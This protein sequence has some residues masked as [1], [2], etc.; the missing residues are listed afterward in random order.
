MRFCITIDE[1][2]PCH[3]CCLWP[4]LVGFGQSVLA[5]GQEAEGSCDLVFGQMLWDLLLLVLV[6]G[7]EPG[8]VTEPE[9][10]FQSCQR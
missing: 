4:G 3:V 1:A 7:R 8:R 6:A 5:F 2:K 10:D 9:T